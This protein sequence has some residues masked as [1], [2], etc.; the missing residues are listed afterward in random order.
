MAQR[1]FPWLWVVVAAVP[2]TLIA[3]LAYRYPD[4][5]RSGDARMELVRGI[6]LL[7]L[8]LGSAFV[9]RRA[10]RGNVLRNIGLWTAIAVAVFALYSYRFE[11]LAI[12]DRLVAELLPHAGIEVAPGAVSIRA[13]NSGH[14]VAEAEVD[15]V[16]VRFLVDT[17][18]SLVVLSP[19][20]AERLG[21]DLKKLD[22]TQRLSTANGIV[23]GAPVRLGRLA[24]GPVTVA[25]VRATVNGAPMDQS[26]LGMSFLSRLSA[27]EVSRETLVLRR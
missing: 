8:L 26:L 2:V 11:L 6:A 24:I 27:Y 10:P 1:P 15:G 19:A 13:D 23:V 22:Y 25:D 5:L 9:H 16:L 17:G 18:A 7:A 21:F 12:K 20:D 4:T 3:W 14:F